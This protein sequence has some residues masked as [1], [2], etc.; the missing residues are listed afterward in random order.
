MTDRTTLTLAELAEL[1]GED[2]A[3]LATYADLGILADEPQYTTSDVERI[4]LVQV[5]CRRGIDPAAVGAAL[6]RQLD[7]FERYLAQLY[8]DNDY[9]SITLAEAAAR[10]GIDV[11]LLHRVR[12]AGGL[13]GPADRLTEADVEAMRAI[14]VGISAGFP[15]DA[16]LQLVRVYADALN[17]VA[18]AEARLFHFYVHERLKAEGLSDDALE[19]ATVGSIA[20][21]V[22]LVE[23]AILYFHRRGLNRAVRDDL[24]L[25]LAE[26]VGLLPPD[27][28]TGRLFAAVAFIDLARFTALTDAMGDAAAADV[29]NRFSD[30]VRRCALAHDGRIVKQIGDEFMLVFGDPR[31]AVGFALDVRD[32]AVAEPRFLGHRQGVHWG[33]VLYRDGDYYGAT[34]NVAARIVAEAGTDRVLVSGA[35]CRE[36]ADP[37]DVEFTAAGRRSLKHVSEPVDVFDVR[38]AGDQVDTIR[39]DDPVCGMSVDP[40][41]PPARLQFAGRDLLFCSPE[42]VRRF[43][44]NPERYT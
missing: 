41:A 31:S 37:G 5:L 36:L 25:H 8:P 39:I 40:E 35:L 21:V 13:G 12:D 24:A 27:D 9:P 23:P 15:E 6:A 19:A 42:C 4:R 32:A 10:T 7:A 16:L 17:R 20:Q 34:V 43:A 29:L 2:A 26:D 22:G 30:L 28:E 3:T 11:A 38:R 1:T 14:T 33:P 18:D 44:A